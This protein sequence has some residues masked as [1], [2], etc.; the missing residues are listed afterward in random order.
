[1]ELVYLP[2]DRD[3]MVSSYGVWGVTDSNSSAEPARDPLPSQHHPPSA[4][5][6]SYGDCLG[7]SRQ[8]LEDGRPRPIPEVIRQ[9]L[10]GVV[11]LIAQFCPSI[12]VIRHIYD[13]E[14]HPDWT[15]RP[16]AFK[17]EAKIVARS[18]EKKWALLVNNLAKSNGEATRSESLPKS[19]E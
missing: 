2:Q 6:A 18:T 17:F 10:D 3:R 5:Y 15:R 14:I 9:I 11:G 4:S 16:Q 1:M 19:S 13:D 8:E 12:Q 7:N